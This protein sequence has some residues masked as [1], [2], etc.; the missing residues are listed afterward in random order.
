MSKWSVMCTKCG[1][2]AVIVEVE[3]K[4]TFRKQ[5]FHSYGRKDELAVMTPDEI[6][7]RKPVEFVE[8]VWTLPPIRDAL[9][10]ECRGEKKGLSV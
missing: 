8:T 4:K 6:N 2:R 7:N 3:A 10:R 9:C 1:K 5:Y